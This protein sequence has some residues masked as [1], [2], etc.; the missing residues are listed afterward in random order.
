MPLHVCL[1]KRHERLTHLFHAASRMNILK[2][3]SRRQ[4]HASSAEE[5]PASAAAFARAAISPVTSSAAHDIVPADIDIII[6]RD[7]DMLFLLVTPAIYTIRRCRQTSFS[8]LCD[9]LS[10]PYRQT[11]SFSRALPPH[12]IAYFARFF[13]RLNIFRQRY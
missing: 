12:Y 1:V 5:Q 8:S 9:I 6:A 11:F 3:G 4:R 13:R 7:I 10:T 2:R